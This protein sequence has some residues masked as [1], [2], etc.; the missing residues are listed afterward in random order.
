MSIIMRI[1]Q[2]F[3]TYNEQ[4]FMA[5]EELFEALEKK[6]SDYPE[7]KR[8]QPISAGEPL[9]S[10]IWQCEFPDI[11]TA[12]ETLDFFSGDAEHEEL[13][14]LQS[15]LIKQVKIEFYKSLDFEH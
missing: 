9:N 12:Y 2:K 5:L 1:I 4:E 15:P 7:G 3:D 10:L 14:K 13:F 11:Q 6:R 8:M